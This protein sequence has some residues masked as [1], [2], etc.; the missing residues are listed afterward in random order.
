MNIKQNTTNFNRN[1]LIWLISLTLMVFAIIIVGGLTRLTNSG[2]SMV[3]WRPILG[4]MPPLNVNDW[5]EVFNLYKTSPEYMYVNQTISLNE[6][7]YI[8]WWEWGHRVLARLIGL[9]FFFPFII[10]FLK[11]I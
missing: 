11:N 6:F 10:L 2:L 9:V 1:I 7:K 5:N 8:F 3:N 4:I